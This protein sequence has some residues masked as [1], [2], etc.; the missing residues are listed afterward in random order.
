MTYQRFNRG[1]RKLIAWQESHTLT[2]S[3]YKITEIFPS[4]ERFGLISQLQRASSSIGAQIAEGSRMSTAA[5][6]RIYYERAYASATEVD[7]FLELSL[8]LHFIAAIQYEQLLERVNRVSYLLHQLIDALDKKPPTL[9]TVRTLPTLPSPPSLHPPSTQVSR[10]HA[11]T[12]AHSP[13][14]SAP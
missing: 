8:D 7:N 11:P 4:S 1:F 13:A 2:V 10:N 6:R 12:A 14:G 3:I 5:H 9:P